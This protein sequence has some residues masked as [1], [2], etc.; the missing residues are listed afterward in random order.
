MGARRDCCIAA[1]RALL[2]PLPMPEIA[3]AFHD[4]CVSYDGERLAVDH[5]SCEI[6]RG[7][8]VALIGASGCGKTSLL[9]T[10]NRLHDASSGE[11]H[12]D[13]D[14]V[15]A[16]DGPSLRRRIGYVFQGV[17]L[18][19]HLTVAEN[20]AITPDLLG[21]SEAEKQA[22]VSAALDLVELPAEFAARMPAELSGGQQQ[23]V[24]LARAMAA[25]PRYL[26]MDEPFAALDP[27][28][29]DRLGA[30]CR[31]LH[32]R[33]GL[34]TI[35]VT[36]DMQESILLADRIIV[37]A[38]GRVIADGAPRALRE[39]A[40]PDLAEMLELPQRQAARVLEVLRAPERR[41]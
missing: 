29:R 24:G 16:Q 35:M 38:Q 13:G 6:A 21:W 40:S 36:H 4:V 41:P 33:L 22:R 31:A 26:L 30:A 25:N 12:V 2:Y 19:P 23:R 14:N 37:M 20:I 8:F 5:V 39:T 15:A 27:L 3:I 9:K 28:T 17:G 7:E 34:T 10:V 11:V 32:D 18:F 1:S